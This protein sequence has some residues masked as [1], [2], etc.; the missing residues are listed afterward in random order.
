M[1][2]VCFQDALIPENFASFDNKTEDSEGHESFERLF[3]QLGSMK[4]ECL[5][6]FRI[7]GKSESVS[8]NVLN[9]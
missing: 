4:G 8:S 3:S 2:S 7:T 9:I 5:I 1:Q 6:R